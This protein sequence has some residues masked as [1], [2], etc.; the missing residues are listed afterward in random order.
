MKRDIGNMGEKHFSSLCSA[1]GITAN[2][3]EI[4]N[5]GWDYIVEFP[6]EFTTKYTDLIK[7]MVGIISHQPID[8]LK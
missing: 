1:A 5:K 8:L 4:D 3:S 2:K 7:R 6:F